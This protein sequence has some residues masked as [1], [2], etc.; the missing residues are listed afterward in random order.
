VK[1][2]VIGGIIEGRPIMAATLARQRGFHMRQLTLDVRELLE[3]PLDCVIDVDATFGGDIPVH[4]GD[5][6]LE[7]RGHQVHRAF[8]M[9][10]WR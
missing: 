5:V 4:P 10:P 8:K 7:I 3:A 6:V 9:L 2:F 1:I